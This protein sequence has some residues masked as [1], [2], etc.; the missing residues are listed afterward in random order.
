MQ[1][2]YLRAICDD[3]P[4]HDAEYPAATGTKYMFSSE[5]IST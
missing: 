1:E 5:G 2:H 4:A 3:V